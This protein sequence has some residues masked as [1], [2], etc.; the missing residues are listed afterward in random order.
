MTFQPFLPFYALFWAL[1][2]STLVGCGAK[3]NA[4]SIPSSDSIAAP[5]DSTAMA[6][7]DEAVDVLAEGYF[8]D[9]LLDPRCW[10]NESHLLVKDGLD[11]DTFL[12]NEGEFTKSLRPSLMA[13]Q[14][15]SKGSKEVV[16][17]SEI[18]NSSRGVDVESGDYLYGW[19][20]SSTLV[21]IFDVDAGR[22]IFSFTPQMEFWQ[23]ETQGD[24]AVTTDSTQYQYEFRFE[25]GAL[26]IGASKGYSEPDL[27][28]GRYL[29]KG[30]DFVRVSQ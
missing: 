29:W 12:L 26:L 14:L 22:R 28:E 3:P 15:N 16:V 13:M 24:K 8:E 5:Q 27:D 23:E 21:E 6:S 20:E 25:G 1:L 2:L 30:T 17:T 11:L 10:V 7:H 9:S 4:D 19:E 18:W